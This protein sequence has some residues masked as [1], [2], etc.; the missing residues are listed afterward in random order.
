MKNIFKSLIVLAA[1]S[2]AAVSCKETNEYEWGEGE[3]TGCYGVYFPV[4]EASGSHTL[5]PTQ[6]PSATITV[7]RTN[8]DGAITVPVVTTFS[9]NDVFEISPISFENGQSETT[10]TL[11]FPNAKEG[12][13][14][15]ASIEIQDPQYASKYN[16][17]PVAIDYSV[18][19][20][21]WNEFVSSDG[22]S[23]V[24]TFTEGWWGEEHDVHIKYYEV[25][26]LRYCKIDGTET[27]DYV[28]SDGSECGG[29]IWGN[30]ADFEFT[31]DT[32]TNK[33]NV[34]KQVMFLYSDNVYAYV[35]GWYEFLISDGGYSAS[36][37]NG[38]DDFYAKNGSGYPQSYYD[39]NGG[40]YFNLR[41]YV[42]GLGGWTTA[43][44]DVVGIASG[45]TRVDYSIELASEETS[46]GVLPVAL[47]LG[48]DVAKV[49]YAAYEGTLSAT[50]ISNKVAGITDGS[51]TN[52][53]EY[54]PVE[55]ENVIGVTLEK[56]G[57][58]TLVAVTFDASGEAHES[59]S[60]E[61]DYVAKGDDV[62]VSVSCGLAATDKY[63]PEGYT[64][65]NSLEYY[66]YGK[67]LKDVKVGIFTQADMSDEQAC[68]KQ[69]KASKS[70]SDS[71]LTVIN[72]KGATDIEAGLSPGTTYYLLVWA[73]NG[74]QSDV[75][76]AS[77]TTNGDPLPVYMKY[78]YASY[79]EEFEPKSESVL[80]GTYNLYGIDAAGKLGMREYLGKAVIADSAT[81]NEGPDADG[82]Y[83]EYFTIKGLGGPA[84]AKAKV[85][86]TMEFDLYGGCFYNVGKTTVDG[87]TT[88][89]VYALGNGK[90]YGGS[91]TYGIPVLDGY[92]AIVSV[93]DYASSYNFSGYGF[94]NSEVDADY[95]F[96]V[97]YD[98][99]LVDPAK[100]NN[101]LAPKA[102][103]A[104]LAQIK[105]ALA[106]A[107]AQGLDG[108][109][110]IRNALR[111]CSPVNLHNPAGIQAEWEGVSV[112]VKTATVSNGFASK[113]VKDQPLSKA[114][115]LNLK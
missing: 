86:D 29:G 9:E 74:Y 15:S 22:K 102:A 8:T 112:P 30:G 60:I 1:V 11:S 87:K 14:Y 3:L 27:C 78:T 85:D 21:S 20:V 68:I 35:Y 4:Q 93:S 41:Y 23:S 110:A 111:N 31:W 106:T 18:M 43:T 82:Y 33:I 47:E 62:P 19:R 67:D 59:A 2:A 54:V 32:K 38:S 40:F 7:K 61:F 70:V 98:Y 107:S 34:P 90:F 58:Y 63:T 53:S 72:G 57:V 84:C 52:V 16:S 39:G 105:K 49:K 114:S 46:D 91:L 81:P 104:R 108:K 5:D 24:V 51:E 10:F 77:A 65:E 71:V 96:A 92:Y 95:V 76:S 45:Y 48:A 6:E 80:Y 64:S 99:L 88:T 42:P 55:G 36:Q 103:E 50:Q 115:A 66:I 113:S 89:Y 25:N 79:A 12:T 100:D 26:G 73:S 97:Y 94:Y 75:I 69:L 109:E 28:Y 17:N 37:W 56:T 83:D 44:F 101:G 13:T